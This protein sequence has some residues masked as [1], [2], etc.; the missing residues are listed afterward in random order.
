MP[1]VVAGRLPFLFFLAGTILARTP[2]AAANDSRL[3]GAF[4]NPP[5]SGWI[6]VHLAGSPAS[7]GYQHGYLLAQEIGNAKRAIAL[8]VTHDVKHDWGEL[9]AVA[10]KT[11]WP[12]VPAEYRQE[13]QGMVEGVRARGSQID[14]MDLVVMNAYMEFPYYYGKADRLQARGVPASVGEALQRVCGD[15]QL[16]KGW[17]Y[18]H[19]A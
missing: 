13:L 11:F 9:R 6:F 4:R 7:I 3:A 8:S 12:S 2:F 18:R 10:E 5:K 14:L 1:N 16:H 15:R 17:P 19:R